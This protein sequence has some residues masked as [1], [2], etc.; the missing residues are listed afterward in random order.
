MPETNPTSTIHLS[1]RLAG[2]VWGHLTG[3][4]VGVPYEFGPPRGADT[5]VF[6][7]RGSHHQPAGTWSDDGALMLAL[8]DSLLAGFDPGD[9]G[10]RA[11]AWQRHGAY[12]PDGDGLF[13]IGRTTSEALSRLASGKKA[14]DAGPAD[15]DAC[16]NG[17]LMRI[18]PVALV[19]R[20]LPPAPL[21]GRAHLASRVTHGHP[22]CQVACAVY[23]VAVVRLLRGQAPDEALAGALA[24]TGRLYTD[25]PGCEAHLAALGELG[26]WTG[27]SGRGFVID[28]FWS[29]WDAFAGA[30]DY[31]DAIRRAVACGDDTDTT[32]AIAGG[33]AGARWGWESIPLD[34]RR[35]MRGH[36]VAQPLVDRL[37][38][39]TGARTSTGSPLRVNELDLDG[40]P[41]HGQGRVGITFLP[42]KK[43]DGYTGP[44]WRDLDLD[45]AR[46]RALGVDT[47][48]LLNEDEELRRALVTE[49][50]DVTA[51]QGPELARFPIPDAH[52]PRDL[53]AYRAVIVDAVER[54]RAGGFVAI[55]CR[56]GIDRSGM[57]AACLLRELGLDAREA[58]R[59]TQ[60][61]RYG[62]ITLGEQQEIV[63]GWPPPDPA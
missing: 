45:L 12:T 1:S 41:L 18:L 9:Q 28:S 31:A 11:L 30:A 63:R 6:G 59:R 53:G 16:G 61:A 10:R 46:L 40:T 55:A 3:D 5:V 54:I 38:E 39:T 58:I 7:A 14:V 4:A 8:L 42:G 37:V 29:A 19:G 27:R 20:D 13:D 23:C 15:E 49:L 48:L 62:S 56:G 17:S 35:G 24:D 51:T 21:I 43:R 25:E 50:P 34:W 32:A 47:L 57:T 2:A 52:V 60:A 44:H 33:L 36:D 22:R 26:A